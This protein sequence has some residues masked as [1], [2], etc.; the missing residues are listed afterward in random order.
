M[1]QNIN[2][3]L[4]KIR[5]EENRNP[6]KKVIEDVNEKQSENGDLRAMLDDLKKCKEKSTA[7][8]QSS[9][10]KCNPHIKIMLLY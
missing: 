1:V 4:K 8:W 2:A 7:F 9:E 10:D 6:M 3:F 5:Y